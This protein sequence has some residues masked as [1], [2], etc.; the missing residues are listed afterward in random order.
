[1]ST[2]QGHRDVEGYMQAVTTPEQEQAGLPL[3]E[4]IWLLGRAA[5]NERGTV[6]C[7]LI[8]A[9]R[10]AGPANQGRYRGLRSD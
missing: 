8:I 6:A 10:A 1:M 7:S 3:E 9:A 5:D 2:T 4:L